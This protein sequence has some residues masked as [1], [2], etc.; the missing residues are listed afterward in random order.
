MEHCLKS[1]VLK[2]VVF[3]CTVNE[4]VVSP[5]NTVTLCKFNS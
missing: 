3:K 2:N 5:V 4:K 1:A